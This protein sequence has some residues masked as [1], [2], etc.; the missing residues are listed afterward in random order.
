M[1][2]LFPEESLYGDVDTGVV[3]VQIHQ[4]VSFV[5]NEDDRGQH[6]HTQLSLVNVSI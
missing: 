5:S 1:K 2:Q 4:L 3:N 6:Y